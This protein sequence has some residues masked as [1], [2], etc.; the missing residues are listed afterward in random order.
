MKIAL[1]QM[2]VLAGQMSKNVETMLR[3]IQQAKKEKADLIVFPEN[4]ISGSLLADKWLDS[5]F[6]ETLC[7]YNETIQK[8]SDGIGIIWGNV[9]QID[10]S[11]CNCAFFAYNQNWVEKENHVLDGIQIKHRNTDSHIYDESRYFDSLQKLTNYSNAHSPFIFNNQRI[12]CILGENVHQEDIGD[13]DLLIHLTSS[14]WTQH[15]E[16]ERKEILSFIHT[17]YVVVNHVGMHNGSK[18]VC[19]YDGDSKIFDENGFCIASCNDC[20]QEEMKITDF[21][22]ISLSERCNDKL[23]KALIV[24][25]QQ[26]DEQVFGKRFK[27][28]IGLSG[29]L[30]SSVNAALLSLALGKNRVLGLNMATRYNSSTTIDNAH[31]LANAC[32]FECRDGIIQPLVDEQINCLKQ[33]TDLEISEFAIENIQARIRGSILS[34]ISQVENGVIINNGNKIEGALG[35]ATLYG[36]AIGCLAPLQDLTKVELFEISRCINKTYQCEVIP[37]NLL[38]TVKGDTIE[39]IMPP[40][41]ELKTNQF[42]PMKWFYHD[43]IIKRLTEESFTAIEDMMKQYL[44]G[45]IYQSEL[46][47]WIKYYHLDNPQ[48]FI[49]DL[50]WILNKIDLGVFKRIQ[51]PPVVILSKG[52]FGND[53]RENQ[54]RFEKSATYLSLKKAILSHANQ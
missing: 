15:K 10:S 13:C 47:K 4:C 28:I 39:W 44:D 8:A 31:K 40:S 14:Y 3:M 48:N 50:E 12:G 25:I 36:D 26:F 51:T 49:E 27:W 11:L 41:A 52:S 16:D 29:G 30:D 46:G 21:N 34:G 1:G 23:L 2:N 9:T 18:N 20:F 38:P 7:S 24:A 6:V 19:V 43:E 5:S 45:T 54:V 17:P 42:D 22:E 35:Y 32:G 33:Y 53:V 37:E